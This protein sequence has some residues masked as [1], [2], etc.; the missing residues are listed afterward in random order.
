MNPGPP[1]SAAAPANAWPMLRAMVGIGV[2]CGIAIVGAFELTRPVIERKRAEALHRAIFEV[3]PG[4]A[5]TRTF[6]LTADGAFEPL[7]DGAR[8]DANE[9]LVHAGYDASGALAGFAL[10][11]S[12]MGYQDTI[13]VLYGYAPG[14]Q[15]I[16]GLRVLESR[17]TPGLGDKIDVDPDFRANFAALDVALD[18]AG[19]APAHPIELVRHG[20]K[21]CQWQIDAITGA[22]VSSRAVA[23]LLRDSAA[24]WTPRLRARLGDFSRESPE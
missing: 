1:L 20:E 11:A 4:A 21:S 22:T 16:V 5:S 8:R 14:P 10:E 17:E 19:A 18:A 7:E 23:D 12:G 9:P 13:R 6:R 24:F 2:V 3:L 15:T